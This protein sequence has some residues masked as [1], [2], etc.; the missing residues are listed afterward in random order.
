MNK[1]PSS[2]HDQIVLNYG[3][4]SVVSIRIEDNNPT[5][6][7][8]SIVFADGVDQNTKDSIN[9]FASSFNWIAPEFDQ[10]KLAVNSDSNIPILARAEL[11]KYFT[12]LEQYLDN[13]QICA[14]AWQEILA[15]YNSSWLTSAVQTEVENAAKTYFVPIV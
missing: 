15:A 5:P 8:Y 12:I 7:V 10:F 6:P 3:A 13:P 9:N 2:L 4:S 11:I 1:F 14:S